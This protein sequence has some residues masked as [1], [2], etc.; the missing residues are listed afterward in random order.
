MNDDFKRI[1]GIVFDLVGFRFNGEIRSVPFDG[2]SVKYDG[3]AAEIGCN[4]KPAF[5]RGCFLLAKGVMAGN[6]QIEIAQKPVFQD[7]G[8]M[9]DASRNGVMRVEAVKRY[10]DNMAALGLNLLLL[11][12]EDTYEIKEYPWFGYLR[13]RYTEEELREIDDYA[14]S[15]GLELV[16]CIQTLAHL[17]QYLK[18]PEG[19]QFSDTEDILLIDEPKTYEFID[20]AIRT[21]RGCFRSKRIHIGMD[22]AHNVGL[23]KYL[24]LH[25]YQNR[26]EI[27]N[28]HLNR[29]VAI[30]KQY[31]FKPMMWSDMFYRLGSKNHAYYDLDTVIPQDVIDQIPDVDMVYWDYY[32]TDEKM[33]RGMIQRH[34]AMNKE[35]IFGGGIWTWAGF[36][37]RREFTLTTSKLALKECMKEDVKTV[38]A[39]MWEDDGC[40]TNHFLTLSLLPVFSEYCYRGMDCTEEDILSAGEFLT[41]I[42]RKAFEAMGVFNME[43][44]QGMGPGKEEIY[45]DIFYNLGATNTDSSKFRDALEVLKKYELQSGN[46]QK[47]YKYAILLFKIATVKIDIRLNLRDRYLKGD[48]DY[49]KQLASSVLP[50]LKEDYIALSKLHREQW[51]A[52]YKPFGLEVLLVRYGGIIERLDYTIDTINQYISG[53][54]TC[55]E[56]L[57]VQRFALSGRIQNRYHR[58]VT[59]SS[60]L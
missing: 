54:L 41:K 23:G 8:V 34:K 10:I 32:N 9:L 6:D 52:T 48:K 33:Y 19:S 20:A 1:Q 56:E 30:C 58:L 28:R 14:D 51:L 40:E 13:G 24:D 7:C 55:I 15:M 11:Y 53:R 31:D 17:S 4:S 50:A 12:T 43:E 38:F 60:I 42:D 2:V 44:K 36:L 49:L 26:F 3:Q 21:L 29:V 27:L 46:N 57:E 25:G 5:A 16:P 45:N 37:P 22:E 59:P 39:T 18:W 47:W 35:V